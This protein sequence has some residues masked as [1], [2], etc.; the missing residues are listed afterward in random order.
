M[1]TEEAGNIFRNSIELSEL[2]AEYEA[3]RVRHFTPRCVRYDEYCIDIEILNRVADDSGDVWQRGRVNKDGKIAWF[4]SL[5]E[6]IETLAG[7]GLAE[8]Y[9]LRFDR[10]KGSVHLNW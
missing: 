10:S 3:G 1:M 7:V 8:A 2:S 9:E 6:C 5:D 4:G